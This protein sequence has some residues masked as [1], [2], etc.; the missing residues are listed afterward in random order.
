MTSYPV[1]DG[2][3]TFLPPPDGYVVDFDNPQ[4]QRAL[5]HYLIFGILGPLALICLVQR[6]Y[7][8][9]FITGS[10]KIDDVLI[11]LAWVASVV[12]QSVQI[13]S[14]SI[15][16]LCH[17]AWEMPIEVFEKH[18][19]SSYIVAPIFITCNGLSKTSLLTFYLQIS[20]Q[21]WFRITIWA[22]II[23]VA[24]YT[25]TI[26][27]LLLFGCK[28][29]RAS[30][31][32]YAFATG[33]CVNAAVMYIA[34]AV[35]NIVSDVILFIIPIPTIVRLKM[36]LVQKVGAGV[37]FGIGSVT[38][39]TSIIRMIYLPSLLGASD[40]PWTAAPAN[41]W[42]FV[43]VNLF[44]ICGSMPTFRKFLKRFAPRLMGSSG[45][46]RPSK[47]SDY[48]ASQRRLNRQQRTEYAQFDV[49]EMD[50]LSDHS[51]QVKDTRM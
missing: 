30:W 26:A 47:Y 21:K 5:D 48:D 49:V 23:M 34:I 46:S 7:T 38:V 14:V 11:C 10:L 42:S 25:T 18:M 2:V 36:P 19:L 39:A 43:E 45:H 12:M 35:A 27:M 3:T 33:K 16:G 31:D 15:G 37:M 44:I 32:P 20:P 13:W 17:H 4:Q 9:H 51:K 29:I 1:T 24:S 6:I 22:T 50:N 8:K 41:V 40:I 28:P